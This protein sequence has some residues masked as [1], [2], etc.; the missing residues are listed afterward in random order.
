[1]ADRQTGSE[2]DEFGLPEVRLKPR[3]AG[4]EGGKEHSGDAD[5]PMPDTVSSASVV[6][7]AQTEGLAPGGAEGPATEVTGNYPQPG[8]PEPRW[9]PSGAPRLLYVLIPVLTV[10][11][12]LK[13]YFY[14]HV[15]PEKV[16]ELKQ[17]A[18]VKSTVPPVKSQKAP[19]ELPPPPKPSKPTTEILL[20]PT[21]RFHVVIK[22]ALDRETIMKAATALNDSGIECL[23]IPANATSP[24]N[25]LVLF[26]TENLEQARVK[27]DSLRSS[28]GAGIWVLKY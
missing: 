13:G 24:S 28:F 14:F 22:S 9:E 3:S 1:M 19:E 20:E 26:S 15:A 2:D 10:L 7:P 18:P 6:G 23:V 5:K 25:R 21:G 8:A 12:A 16:S 17:N 4:V 11:L 27:A